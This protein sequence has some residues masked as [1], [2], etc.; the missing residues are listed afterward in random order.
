MLG[1]VYGMTDGEQSE[2]VRNAILKALN[3]TLSRQNKSGVCPSEVGGWRC[4][5]SMGR[6]YPESDLSITS[7]GLMFLR[8]AKNTAFDVPGENIEA[9]MTY[10]NRCQDTDGA[11]FY[12]IIPNGRTASRSMMGSGILALGLGGR[13]ESAIAKRGVDWLLQ[14][15]FRRY[16]ETFGMRDRFHYAAF[17][18]SQAMMQLGGKYWQEFYPTLTRTLIAGQE[19]DGSWPL[20]PWVNDH[21]FGDCYTT[22]LAVLALTPPY[23]LIPIFQR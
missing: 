11:Y 23:Q 14:H 22:S 18:C 4:L 13:H 20:E 10:V 9:A 12:G 8:S 6:G 19:S 7:W 5:R 1:E 17:Y 3:V 15:P 21:R 16:H 2:R